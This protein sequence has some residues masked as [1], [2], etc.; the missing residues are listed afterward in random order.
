MILRL[1]DG[2]FFCCWLITRDL[3]QKVCGIAGL[4]LYSMKDS[5][6][7]R[8]YNSLGSCCREQ[9]GDEVFDCPFGA[10]GFVHGGWCKCVFT[11]FWEDVGGVLWG[12]AP[13]TWRL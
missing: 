13:M 9:V 6:L 2:F 5:V 12:C 1:L 3:L 8:Y 4:L 7:C 11:R 10:F